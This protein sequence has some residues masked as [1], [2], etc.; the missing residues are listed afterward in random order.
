MV[1]GQ[2]AH[3]HNNTRVFNHFFVVVTIVYE[4]NQPLQLIII[5]I[6]TTAMAVD[7]IPPHRAHRVTVSRELSAKRTWSIVLQHAERKIYEPRLELRAIIIYDR[8]PRIYRGMYIPASFRR[9]F[10]FFNFKCSHANVP[11]KSILYA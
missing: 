10:F 3:S 7:T 4:H 1:S 8:K 6:F 5:I 11:I 9:F 2:P